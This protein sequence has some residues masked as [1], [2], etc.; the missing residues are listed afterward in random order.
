MAPKTHN[1]RISD[2]EEKVSGYD[3]K[4]DKILKLLSREVSEPKIMPVNGSEVRIVDN[5]LREMT[6]EEAIMPIDPEPILVGEIPMDGHGNILD[7]AWKRE[8]GEDGIEVYRKYDQSGNLVKT[9]TT[10]DVDRN[11]AELDKFQ[12]KHKR[13]AESIGLAAKHEVSTV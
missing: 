10:S 12:Q 1:K 13:Y 4:L 6:T 2:L 7:P 3:S 5:G 8:K 11:I 9:I